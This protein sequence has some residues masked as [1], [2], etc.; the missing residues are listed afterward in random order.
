MRLIHLL[1]AATML[2]S[3]GAIAQNSE[4][5]RKVQMTLTAEGYDT[6]QIDGRFGPKTIEA[7]KQ[8]QQDRELEPTG[9]LD[10]RT[11]AAFGI[12][13]SERAAARVG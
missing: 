1:I 13:D 5:V 12:S 11:L 9:K 8:A 10:D 6:G 3:S 7:V 4:I 2:L